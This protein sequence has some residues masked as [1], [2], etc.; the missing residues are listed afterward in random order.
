MQF[1][2]A[3]APKLFDQ[4]VEATGAKS[5]KWPLQLECCGAPLMGT[6]DDLSMDLTEKKLAD[7]KASG[8]DYLCVGCPWC[9]V[10]FDRVQEM[11]GPLRGANHHLPSILYPQ[12]IGLVMGI[13]G[14]ALGIGDNRIDIGGIEGFYSQE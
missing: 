14:G 2:D 10:Q 12:L 8:A 11:M 1:D 7:G 9:Q 3:V 5:I 6:N 13:D 4:L